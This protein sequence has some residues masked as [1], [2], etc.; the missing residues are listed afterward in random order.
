M[1]TR[2]IMKLNILHTND[3]H[4][5]IERLAYAGNYIKE[6]RTSNP[7]T[8]LVDSGDMITGDFQFK[9]NQG[10]A[11]R[12]INNYLKYDVVT[13]GNH[14][15]DLD[16]QFLKEHMNEINAQYVLSNVIDTK[17][18]I[19]D[20]SQ[21]YIKD[22]NGVKVGFISFLLPY[23][24][25]HIETNFG[26][27]T[28][29]EFVEFKQAQ[30][31]IDSI[32]DQ[33]DVLVALNHHGID[34]DIMLASQTKGIDIIIGA[35]SHTK[36]EAPLVENGTYIFQTGCFA[37]YIG[38]I[39]ID[40]EDKQITAVN[41]KLQEIEEDLGVDSELQA[42]IDRH[43]EVV[44]DNSREVYGSCSH[45][46]EGKREDLIRNS[47][48][49]GSLICDSYI[50]YA[51][52]IGYDPNFAIINARGLRQSIEPGD[53]TYQTLYNV[54]PFEK[55][56][57]IFE[58]TGAD[59]KG[60]LSNKIELQSSGLKIIKDDTQKQYFDQTI[61]NPIEDEEIYQVVTM[62]YLFNHHQFAQ[63]HK[64]TV[65]RDNIAL[66]IEVVSSYIKKLGH[67]FT[68]ENNEMVEYREKL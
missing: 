5:N 32:R 38:N 29:I 44:Q 60:G 18:K 35:H 28:G 26:I 30:G 54:M 3:I 25:T 33:V 59:L 39:E 8:L 37:K 61:D 46:L 34:R 55:Q 23:T 10:Q 6:I 63:L 21:S 45:R 56:L 65:L 17:G 43:L 2:R 51:K 22:V 52:A 24:K 13:V 9:F 31:I 66:D 12:E 4:S 7:N 19:G 53:I 40:V 57:V 58:I 68:Y 47:T 64:G 15:F 20:Y 27:D 48:N 67:S 42:I 41:Y 62:D 1:R 49:L 36:L 14:D 50:D 16:F 11:E